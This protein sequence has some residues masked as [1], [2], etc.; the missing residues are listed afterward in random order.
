VFETIGEPVGT[1]AE[2]RYRA[3]TEQLFVALNVLRPASREYLAHLL[4]ESELF[5]RQD[6][7]SWAYAPPPVEHADA[8]DDDD[9]DYDDDE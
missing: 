6:E 4:S 2:P 3:S 9:L 5:E 1:R 7:T 8:D